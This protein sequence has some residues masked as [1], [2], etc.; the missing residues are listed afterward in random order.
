MIF[1]RRSGRAIRR[2]ELSEA[3]WVFA[4]P[5]P[6]RA[7]RRRRRLDARTVL[8]AGDPRTAPSRR[9]RP[10]QVLSRDGAKSHKAYALML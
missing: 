7:E 2:H 6:P 10:H 5:L 3:D 1:D 9:V 4:Q 8:N